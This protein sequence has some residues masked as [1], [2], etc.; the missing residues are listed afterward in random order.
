[1]LQRFLETILAGNV[2]SMQ[3]VARKLD[4]S[5]ALALQMAVDLTKKGYLQELG[6]DCIQPDQGCPDCAAASTCQAITRH[7]FLTEKGRN[8]VSGGSITK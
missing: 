1:M 5:P 6:A 4:V 2:Q 7:W 3:E 8:V